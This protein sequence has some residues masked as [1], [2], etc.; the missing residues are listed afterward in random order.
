MRAIEPGLSALEKRK[1]FPLSRIEARFV[2]FLHRN[3]DT[4]LGGENEEK[5]GEGSVDNG[6]GD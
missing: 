3:F 4:M 2:G 5:E 6:N 1:R